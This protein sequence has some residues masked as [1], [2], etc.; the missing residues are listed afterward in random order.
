MV[1]LVVQPLLALGVLPGAV[2]GRR[3][4][5]VLGAGLVLFVV[6]HVGALWITSPPDVVDTLT[7]TSPT[8]FFAWGVIAMW[9]VFAAALLAVFRKRLGPRHWRL[10]HGV[11][12]FVI[13]LGTVI[14]AV[15]IEGRMEPVS[16]AVLAVLV[17]N[18]S[19]WALYRMR[20]WMLLKPR[21]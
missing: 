15:L 19:L 12:T 21:K 9:S 2:F 5:R 10:F 7:F 14:H 3:M 4:H 6:V 1:L 11:L 17:L 20:I 8:S 18:A 16:K 13:A